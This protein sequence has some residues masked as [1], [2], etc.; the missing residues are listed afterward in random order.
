MPSQALEL[1]LIGHSAALSACEKAK[2]WE[3][4]L[5]TTSLKYY[6]PKI[7]DDGDDHHDD[8]DDDATMTTTVVQFFFQILVCIDAIDLVR[9]SSKSELFSRFFGRSGFWRC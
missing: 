5:V 1:S 7:S 9:K 8:D 3:A 2:E 6:L 4:A